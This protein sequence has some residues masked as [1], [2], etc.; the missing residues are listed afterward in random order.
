MT[1]FGGTRKR[2]GKAR[3]RRRRALLAVIGLGIVGA[4]ALFLFLRG[5]EAP[6]PPSDFGAVLLELA[7]TRGADSERVA[8]DEPIRKIDG[9][10]VRSWQIA[11]PN[12]TALAAL[13]KDIVAAASAR[14]GTATSPAAV[15]DDTTRVRV[16]FGDEAFDVLLIV[17]KPVRVAELAPTAAPTLRPAVA[18]AT[19]RP[20]PAP[21]ARGRL[22]ILL[23]DAG[24]NVDLLAAAASLPPE[25]AVAVL[26]FLPHSAEVAEALYGSGHEVWLH[27]PMEPEGFPD[28]DPGPGAV[29]VGMADGEIRSAVHA[30]INNVPH[31]I[32][33]NNHMGSRASADLRV[34]TWVMQE[35]RARGLAFIDSR[36]TRDTVAEDAARALGVP[37]GRRHVF[38]DNTR[39]SAAIRAQLDEAVD[40]C[41]LEGATIAIGHLDPITVRTLVGELPGLAK[42]GA[43]LVKPST[44]LR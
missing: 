33:V 35:L 10:F 5:R 40:R 19:P 34:M 16:D 13:G 1:I 36:T 2:S 6:V 12:Q 20:R 15:S 8:A 31:V 32:G 21:G 37:A 22:A 42:R 44:L 41:R 7:A 24:Q 39:S 23:D 27:L 25:V 29:L 9:V 14:R 18:T 17:A 4:I 28:N 26:P 11:V 30:A 3:S 38:L 43:D